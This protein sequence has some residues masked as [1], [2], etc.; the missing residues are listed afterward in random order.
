VPNSE[1]STRLADPQ[2]TVLV[3]SLCFIGFVTVLH[4]G[5]KVLSFRK[6]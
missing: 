4:A 3:M 1:A 6:S 5:A 2:V